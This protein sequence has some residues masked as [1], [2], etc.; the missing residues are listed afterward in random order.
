MKSLTN[1]LL[2]HPLIISWIVLLF[3]AGFGIP[4]LLDYVSKNPS[5]TPIVS[6][7]LTALVAGAIAICTII[8]QRQTAR[9]NNSLSFEKDYKRCEFV[10]N[11]WDTLIYNVHA[12]RLETPIE[13]YAIDAE[14]KKTKEAKAIRDILNE[15]ERA[16]N[17]V[18]T[19]LYDGEF[20]YQVFG[21]TVIF[22]HREMLPYIKE[23]QKESPFFYE[24]FM[25][26]A[27]CW[28][29][30]RNQERKSN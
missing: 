27:V 4:P 21:S 20:L 17:A 14:L 25:R 6:S 19:R 24:Q 26:L 8:K 15:W 10:R 22:L 13:R 29:A 30:K 5:M 12:N 9:E 2:K 18:N 16:A 23:R 28:L 1:S 11:A 7:G 3:F